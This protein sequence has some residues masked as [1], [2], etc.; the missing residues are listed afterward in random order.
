MVACLSAHILT[1]GQQGMAGGEDEGK[2]GA[3]GLGRDKLHKGLPRDAS[4]HQ[5]CSQTGLPLGHPYPNLQGTRTPLI[6]PPSP[7]PPRL[8]RLRGRVLIPQQIAPGRDRAPSIPASRGGSSQSPG[9]GVSPYLQR[10][11]GGLPS[12]PRPWLGRR[13]PRGPAAAQARDRE[14]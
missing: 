3:E 8:P 11:R 12:A 7:Q 5:G 13:V 10:S 14:F 1:A 2:G 4:K 9:R 6:A